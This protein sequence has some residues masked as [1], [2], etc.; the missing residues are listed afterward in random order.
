MDVCVCGYETKVE[1][2]TSVVHSF[3]YPF[4]ALLLLCSYTI[5]NSSLPPLSFIL[6][7]EIIPINTGCLNNCTYCKTKHARGDLASYSIDEIVSRI[8]S[9]I[10]GVSDLCAILFYV[11]I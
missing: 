6:Q 1:C 5:A 8:K 4:P 2:S 11:Q 10:A 3:P 7:I 9:V